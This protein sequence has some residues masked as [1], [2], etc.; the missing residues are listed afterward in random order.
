MLLEYQPP[1][2]SS[3]DWVKS[4]S[5]HMSVEEI[6][7]ML[8]KWHAH[9]ASFFFF[10]LAVLRQSCSELT[11][12]GS[13]PRK[14]CCFHGQSSASP[15][16]QLRLYLCLTVSLQIAIIPDYV[17]V[18]WSH[19]SFVSYESDCSGYKWPCFTFL[20]DEL[21]KT[22]FTHP[23]SPVLN[24]KWSAPDVAFFSLVLCCFFF[25]FNMITFQAS[26]SF[27]RWHGQQLSWCSAES[28]FDCDLLILDACSFNDQMMNQVHTVQSVDYIWKSF[29]V[30]PHMSGEVRS[31]GLF[32]KHWIIND[33]C[34]RPWIKSQNHTKA[35][36]VFFVLSLQIF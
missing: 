17:T 30:L 27:P 23:T 11:S 6:V 16:L 10:F 31:R 4:A 32:S 15:R 36:M 2:L 28:K 34:E 12:Q 35:V 20:V 21:I 18:F 8:T 29:G 14:T 9:V 1:M 19:S 5:A 7:R 24:C 33:V 3:F 13:P 25:F 22:Q 26:I